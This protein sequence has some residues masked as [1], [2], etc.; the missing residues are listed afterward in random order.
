MTY[1]QVLGVHDKE[2]RA[3]TTK[4]GNG[5]LN[6]EESVVSGRATGQPAELQVCGF[7]ARASVTCM[8]EP[9]FVGDDRMWQEE[10]IELCKDL[11]SAIEL[12]RLI[13]KSDRSD[14][15]IAN[16]SFFSVGSLTE[17]RV[18]QDVITRHLTSLDHICKN[19]VAVELIG[20]NIHAVFWV[21][22][23]P[24]RVLEKAALCN[25]RPGNGRMYQK[26]GQAGDVNKQRTANGVL[27]ILF[28]VHMKQDYMVV[29]E[30][31]FSGGLWRT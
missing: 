27:D 3:H 13:A 6:C 4:D 31:V 19:K 9:G 15:P 17:L 18:K 29:C 26:A 8:P 5:F 1:I 16:S 23:S 28:Y 22:E 21:Q 12:C 2:S 7:N 14:Q 25:L 11:C 10:Y 24:V 30:L 20:P